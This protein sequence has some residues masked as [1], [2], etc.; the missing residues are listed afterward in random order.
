MSYD[1]LILDLDRAVDAEEAEQFGGETLEAAAL[2]EAEPLTG[3]TAGFVEAITAG[4]P[5][6]DD[7]DSPWAF[8]PDE[9]ASGPVAG[10]HL[11][12]SHAAATA[13]RLAA[14][15]AVHDLAFLDQQTGELA[16][17]GRLVR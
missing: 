5:S 4:F 8:S 17:P 10:I 1:L 16:L 14:L 2:G 9:E 15:A 6:M 12:A 3:R 7:D 11:R 13:P